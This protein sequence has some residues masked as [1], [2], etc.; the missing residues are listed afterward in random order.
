MARAVV[1]IEEI[2]LYPDTQRILLKSDGGKVRLL[3]LLYFNFK[4]SQFFMVVSHC[5]VKGETQ[6]G[7]DGLDE[8]AGVFALP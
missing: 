5:K 8:N 7:T 2:I 6:K 1:V 4:V 3:K